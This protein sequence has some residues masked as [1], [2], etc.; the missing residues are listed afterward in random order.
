MIDLERLLARGRRIYLVDLLWR[1]VERYGRDECPAYAAAIAFSLLLSLF[2]L[3]I[4]FVA[5]FGLLTALPGFGPWVAQFTADRAPGEG[6][7][8]L[9]ESISGV[10]VVGNSVAG[11]IGL[12]ALVW[13]ASGMFG[14]LRQGLNR[15]FGVPNPPQFIRARAQSLLGVG[16]LFLIGLLS[17]GLTTVLGAL[18]E[19]SRHPVGGWV[20]GLT[21][22]T[23]EWLIPYATLV[24]VA[25]LLYLL[26]P[27]HALSASE[28]WPAALIAGT[29]LHLTI[30]GFG[31][32][33]THFAQFQQVYGA[34]AGAVALLIFLNFNATIIL[35]AAGL[36]AEMARDRRRATA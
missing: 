23:V 7:R 12:A 25:L 1:T 19:F 29:G 35:F 21:Q 4:V 27:N 32:Y 11:F 26:I 14:A 6:L 22:G 10:P 8:Q 9:V 34:L 17:I 30:I 28:L 15:A 31:Y 36:A 5:V 33:V 18:R 20:A 16:I 2:P 3:L 24:S 13:A